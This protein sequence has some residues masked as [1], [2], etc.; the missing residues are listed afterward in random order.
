ML[1]ECLRLLDSGASLEDCLSRYPDAADDLR[2]FLELRASLTAAT[3]LDP[4]AG[5]YEQ[6]RSRLLSQLEAQPAARVSTSFWS[7]I[8]RFFSGDRRWGGGLAR[9]AAGVVAVFVLGLGALGASAAGGFEPARDALEPA[10]D[11]LSRLRII[12][13]DKERDRE[14]ADERPTRRETDA[15]PNAEETRERVRDMATPTACRRLSDRPCADEARPTPTP[16]P[17]RDARATETP[18]KDARATATPVR[19]APIRPIDR[20]ATAERPLDVAPIDPPSDEPVATSPRDGDR[21][22]E[23]LDDGLTDTRSGEPKATIEPRGGDLTYEEP[24]SARTPEAPAVDESGEDE[25]RS[26]PTDALD[27]GSGD[28]ERTDQR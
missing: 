9:A 7:G 2:P 5:A 19:D 14:A 26:G 23:P 16:T 21:S 24:V 20:V 3:Q 22:D 28:G 27:G 18:R 8:A 15:P 25:E 17:K 6:G 12:S 4:P 1:E 10:R 13:D 11:V